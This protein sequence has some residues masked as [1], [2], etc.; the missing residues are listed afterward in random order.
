MSKLSCRSADVRIDNELDTDASAGNEAKLDIRLA[1]HHPIGS[2]GDTF[3]KA[4]SEDDHE[5]SVVFQPL[6]AE[7]SADDPTFPVA[8]A[9]ELICAAKG[10]GGI[11]LTSD[12]EC[13]AEVSFVGESV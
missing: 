6:Q 12:S 11:A 3:N 1:G 8:I 13:T 4:I 5:E 7:W 9:L 10:P 2:T